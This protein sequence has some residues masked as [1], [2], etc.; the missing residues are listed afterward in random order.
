V[1]D[2]T[3]TGKVT[4]IP[5]PDGA[6]VPATYGGVVVKASPHV[7]AATAFLS[8]LA[9]PDGQAIFASFGFRPPV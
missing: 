5:I 3:S 8:W 2:A 1:T 4:S 6:N 9:G 7:D